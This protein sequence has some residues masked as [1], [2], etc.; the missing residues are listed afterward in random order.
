M[1]IDKF[2]DSK[3]VIAIDAATATVVGVLTGNELDTQNYRSLTIPIDI[4]I[5]TGTITAV[6]FTESDT[7]GGVF[8]AV[9]GDNVLFNPDLLPV[10]VDGQ[11]IVGCIAKKRFVKLTITA[12]ATTIVINSAA[13]LLQDS[14][15][16]PQVK[17]ASVIA[18][19]DVSS[20]GTT[21]DA[22]ST[23]PKR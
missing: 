15:T 8:T 22:A 12:D 16:A 13:G 5:T 3:A 11:L 7:T 23:P 6:G 9:S 20:P 4:D 21:G 17:A 10:T 2:S 18:D 14:L 19:A 1:N